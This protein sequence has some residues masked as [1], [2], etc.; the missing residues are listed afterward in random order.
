ML[1]VRGADQIDFMMKT[2]CWSEQQTFS[3]QGDVHFL[4]GS[5]SEKGPPALYIDPSMDWS[6]K[7][8]R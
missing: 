6:K 4:P 3:Q 1:C 5:V 2:G 7:A 8:A